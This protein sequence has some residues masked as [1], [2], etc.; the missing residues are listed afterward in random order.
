MPGSPCA[1]TAGAVTERP[2]GMP[3]TGLRTEPDSE[4]CG[5]PLDLMGQLADLEGPRYNEARKRPLG[6]AWSRDRNQKYMVEQ[7]SEPT[8]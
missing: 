3:D 7:R 6:E 4:N 1:A 5:G 2:R 8:H